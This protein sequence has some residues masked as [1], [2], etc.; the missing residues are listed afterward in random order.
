MVLT[1]TCLSCRYWKASRPNEVRLGL[2]EEMM[3]F[4][5]TNDTHSAATEDSLEEWSSFS[6]IVWQRYGDGIRAIV[7]SLPL[8]C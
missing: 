2:A 3:H 1:L 8:L 4:V 6:H 5:T 7:Q